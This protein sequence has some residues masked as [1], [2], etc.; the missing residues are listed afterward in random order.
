MGANRLRRTWPLTAEEMRAMLAGGDSVAQIHGRAYRLDASV[1][2]E[3]V[4]AILF[5]GADA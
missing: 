3:R 4:R 5:H 2:K 1:T